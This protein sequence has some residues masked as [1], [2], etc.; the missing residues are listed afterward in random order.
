MGAILE[1]ALQRAPIVLIKAGKLQDAID[2]Y[3]TMLNAIETKTTQSLRLTLARQLAEVLLRGVSGTI[4]TPPFHKKQGTSSALK[5]SGSSKKLW[6]PRKYAARNQ[7]VP[8]SRRPR[9]ALVVSEDALEEFPDNLNLLH[10][11]AHLQLHLQDAEVAL[12]TVQRMLAI[13]RELYEGQVN[14]E[15]EEKQS[16]T[17]SIVLH[18]PSS[19]MSDKDSS[20]RPAVERETELGKRKISKEMVEKSE[21]DE[22]G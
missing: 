22:V 2:R 17:K 21:R 12:V 7:F 5:S 11:K 19:Q 14:I 13:W 4:Y 8:P 3:R 15:N 16:D 9:E 10:V 18:V 6:K 20:T 1:T